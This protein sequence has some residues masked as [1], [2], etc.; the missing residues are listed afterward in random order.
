MNRLLTIVD[1]KYQRLEYLESTGTQYID[2]GV[3]ANGLITI[4]CKLYTANQYGSVFGSR[5]AYG[6]K[7]FALTNVAGWLRADYNNLATNFSLLNSVR[8][9]KSKYTETEYIFEDYNESEILV[10]SA[11]FTKLN[12]IS[13]L[14]LFLFARND[15]GVP[16]LDSRNKT[17]IYYFKIYDNNRLV[18]NFV[19]VLRKTD[20]VLGMLDLVEGKFYSNAGTGKFTANLDTMYAIIQGSPTQSSYGVFS[21]FS[22]TNYLAIQEPF[23]INANTVAEFVFKINISSIASGYSFFG[24]LNSYGLLISMSNA[25]RLSLYIGDGSSW[26]IASGILTTSVLSTDTDYFVKLIFNKQSVSLLISTDGI[27]YTGATTTITLNQEYVYDLC[28][29]IGRITGTYFRGS[30]D[31]NNSYIKLGSTKYNLQAVVGYTVVGSPT[32]VDGVASGFNSTASGGASNDYITL[33]NFT[34][35]ADDDFEFVCRGNYERVSYSQYFFYSQ[36]FGIY[37]SGTNTLQFIVVDSGG[38]NKYLNGDFTPSG[39]FVYVR[40][41]KVGN[42]YTT[43]ASND[44]K[45]WTQ[46]NTSTTIT[47]ATTRISTNNRFGTS[48]GGYS[49]FTGEIDLNNTYIKINNKLWFNGQQA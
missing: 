31:L 36:H 47:P 27:A 8:I 28:Y 6:N 49:L 13:D 2:T 34:L 9:I 24:T 30:I 7:S 1:S 16:N 23:K 32:I 37:H 22:G 39:D 25:G 44:G 48:S 38:A 35:N 21:G 3:K 29:G 12:F 45:I 17:K 15:N 43:F 26:N 4:D 40:I 11:T 14:N 46:L 18:R 33:P 5:I 41:T 20:N 42:R 19:P 10:K